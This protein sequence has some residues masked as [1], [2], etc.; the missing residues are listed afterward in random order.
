MKKSSS[1]KEDYLKAIYENNGIDEFVS[2]KSLAN[3]LSV[4]PASV[5]EMV[6][7]LQKDGLIEYKPYTGVKLTDEGLKKTVGIIRNHRIIETFLFDKLDY[8]LHDL[9]NLSEELEHVKDPVFFS[10]LYNYLGEPETCPHGGIIPTEEVFIE[11]AI[12]PIA[13][14]KKGDSPEIRRV[15]DN[16][17]ILNYMGSIGLTIGDTIHITEVDVFNEL[18]LFSINDKTDTHHI[19]FKQAQIIFSY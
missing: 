13:T 18:M 15:M 17:D 5:T 10:R 4:S 9:H 14:F 1:N 2:N 11:K 8:S 3:H 7:K 16:T 19:S 6:E 12:K